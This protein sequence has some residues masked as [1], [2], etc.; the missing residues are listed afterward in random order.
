MLVLD[1]D[2]IGFFEIVSS[3]HSRPLFIDLQI[4]ME[5]FYCTNV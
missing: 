4:F 1:I 3:L 2:L 5:R